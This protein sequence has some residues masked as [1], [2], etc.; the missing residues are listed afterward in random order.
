MEDYTQDHMEVLKPLEKVKVKRV[1]KQKGIP[2]MNMGSKVGKYFVAHK[3]KGMSKADAARAAGI[4]SVTNVGN[5]EK[6]PTFK[7]LEIKYKDV[8]LKHI[9]MDSVAA[10]HTKNIEQDRDLGAKNKAIELFL[11]YV[12]PEV[13]QSKDDDTM[14]VVLRE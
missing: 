8:M 2:T 7:A 1:S 5:Y 9:G 3:V 10:E 12:E 13:T 4:S 6:L 11:K 14:I